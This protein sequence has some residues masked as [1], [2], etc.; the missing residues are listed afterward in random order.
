MQTI[1][2][3]II[4]THEVS[5]FYFRE[6]RLLDERNYAQWLGV[7][8]P[9]IVYHMPSR[10]VAQPDP[11]L[12][13]TED[14][15]SLRHEVGGADARSSPLRLDTFRQLA[16]RAMRPFKVNAWA[17][18]PPPRTRRL[19]SNIEI[20]DQDDATVTTT[21]NFHLFYSHLGASNHSYVGCRRD[22]LRKEEA[23]FKLL[24]RQ[25]IIDWDVVTGPTLALIF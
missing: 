25:V 7:L 9:A 16:A 17:E 11:A 5:Q 6:A 21:S 2:E 12:K 23:G 19:I 13:G 24:Q 3:D 14:F 20:L 22:K 15:L 4:L 8:D 1:S 18:S 10:H